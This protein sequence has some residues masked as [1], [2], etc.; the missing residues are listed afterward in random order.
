[1]CVSVF[2]CKITKCVCVSV[3][4]RACVCQVRNKLNREQS[5]KLQQNKELLNKKNSE[6]TMMDKRIGDLRERLQKKRAEARH[7]DHT[8][9]VRT[10]PLNPSQIKP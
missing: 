9:S 6:V 1:M 8:R 3:C 2:T 5:G 10:G 4:V 7:T